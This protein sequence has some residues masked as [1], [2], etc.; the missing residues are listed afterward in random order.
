MAEKNKMSTFY[1]AQ[2]AFFGV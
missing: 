2:I 1:G